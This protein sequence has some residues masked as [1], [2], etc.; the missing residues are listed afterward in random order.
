MF[1]YSIKLNRKSLFFR[2]QSEYIGQ[3]ELLFR[4]WK[5]IC[6]MEL[7]IYFQWDLIQQH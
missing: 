6:T 4:K 5:E 7:E 3:I 1:S 2:L